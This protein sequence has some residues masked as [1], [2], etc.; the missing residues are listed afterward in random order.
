MENPILKQ[1]QS[2]KLIVAA[3]LEKKIRELAL[4]LPSKEWSGV[5]FYT[6]TGSIK[7]NNLI[8]LAEDCLPMDIGSSS[9]TSFE[10]DPD[11]INYMCNNDL[12]D[13]YTGLVH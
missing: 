7:D 6:Y 11:I 10:T 5:L 4:L 1:Q 13:C 8:I 2:Y 9:Y 3:K 12:I